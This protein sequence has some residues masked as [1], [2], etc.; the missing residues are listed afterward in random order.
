VTSG[1]Y[2]RFFME[3]DIRYHHILDTKT[4]Y[5]ADSG[6]LSVTIISANSMDA[7]ALSTSLFVLGYEKGAAVLSHFPGAEAV[8]VLS[9]TTI[10]R[11]PAP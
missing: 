8:F 7:D 6:L 11:A 10:R 9:D 4:G 1:V 3:N 2:E 5:P